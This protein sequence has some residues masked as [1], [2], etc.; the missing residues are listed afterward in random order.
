MRGLLVMK[1]L[2]DQKHRN[3]TATGSQGLPDSTSNPLTS[4]KTRVSGDVCT[5]R[6]FPQQRVRNVL[7]FPEGRAPLT[8]IPNCRVAAFPPTVFKILTSRDRFSVL[9]VGLIPERPTWSYLN[10][11][12]I[13]C[14]RSVGPNQVFKFLTSNLKLLGFLVFLLVEQGNTGCLSFLF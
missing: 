3:I 14:F 4:V 7:H 8:R 10:R 11:W 2:N 6:C 9:N 1:A 12:N 13:F 5:A